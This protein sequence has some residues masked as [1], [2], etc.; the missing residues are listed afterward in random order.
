MFCSA[1][2]SENTS[3]GQPKVA[4]IG[5]S[6]TPKTERMPKL[7]VSTIEPAAMMIVG[8]RQARHG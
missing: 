5:S 2:L 4:E 7:S 6:M 8:V 1:R 3:R